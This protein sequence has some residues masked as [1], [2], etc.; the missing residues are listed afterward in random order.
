[1]TLDERIDTVS[2]PASPMEAFRFTPA[3]VD[4]DVPA[5]AAAGVDY[6]FHPYDGAGHALQNFPTPERYRK[7]A[8]EDAR[9]KVLT[10][11][12]RTLGT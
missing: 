8:S 3:E 4:D 7:T 6:T 2:V 12:P 10:F 5:L 1:M 11:L 9:D